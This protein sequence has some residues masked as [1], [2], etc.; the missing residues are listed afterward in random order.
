[1]SLKL[2]FELFSINL[3]YRLSFII[4]PRPKEKINDSDPCLSYLHDFVFPSATLFPRLLGSC[5][6]P[7]LHLL[8][9]SM[10]KWSVMRWMANDGRNCLPSKWHLQSLGFLTW[11]NI[12]WSIWYGD[13]SLLFSLNIFALFNLSRVILD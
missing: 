3:I 12:H 5:N 7:L 8:L 13:A 10:R 9:L 6:S 2:H 1:M 4:D 11:S